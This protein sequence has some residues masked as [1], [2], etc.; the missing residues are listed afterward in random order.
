MLGR[1]GLRSSDNR[2]VVARAEASELDLRHTLA[3]I[4]Q[5]D[6]QIAALRAEL[7]MQETGHHAFEIGESYRSQLQQLDDRLNRWRQT[8][9]DLK[10]H[11]EKVEHNATDARLDHQLGEQLSSSKDADP[12]AALRSL[13]AQIASTRKQLD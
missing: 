13:E 7:K 9:R 3:E 11:R 10:S 1:N 4:E 5:L 8:L 6:R 2:S 12:R